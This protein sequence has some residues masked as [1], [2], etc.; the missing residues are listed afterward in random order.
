MDITAA[1]F[2]ALGLSI[3]NENKGRGGITHRHFAH[4]IKF[5]F[6][7]KGYKAYLEWVITGTNHPVDV[8]VESNNGWEVFEIC[9]TATDNLLSH[10][11]ACFEKSDIVEN[12]TIMVPTKTRAKELKKL[13][14][15]N[16]MFARYDD[17]I[18]VDIMENYMPKEI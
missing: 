11:E 1:G 2:K 13:I 9:V 18:K 4:W 17:R 3:P 7:K 5:Q 10:I 16:L 6:E 8:A 14:R 12:L 15:S